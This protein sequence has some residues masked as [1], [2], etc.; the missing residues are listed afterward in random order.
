VR[1]EIRPAEGGRIG[2]VQVDGHELLVTEGPGPMWS[3]CF[4]MAPFAGRTR[5]GRFTF[6]ARTLQLPLNYPPHAIHGFVL[7]RPWTRIDD[8]TIATDLV[9]PW[10]FRGRV[11]QRFGLSEDRLE[12]ALELLATDSMPASIGWHP[13]FARWPRPPV[14]DGLG[15]I[16]LDFHP[17]SM[18][19]RD[20]EGIATGQLVA[21][22]DPASCM[23]PA[24]TRN[25]MVPTL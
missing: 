9:D 8:R 4:P 2:S 24:W 7:D 13:W 14:G 23:G 15:P 22:S 16:E 19:L 10:P 12:V 1:V 11:V 17:A 18:Y 6:G 20:S 21:P 25:A 5:H 3:G